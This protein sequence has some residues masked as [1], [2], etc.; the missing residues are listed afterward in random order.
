M[1]FDYIFLDTSPTF[2]TSGQFRLL[3]SPSSWSSPLLTL[4]LE[5]KAPRNLLVT[6]NSLAW[7]YISAESSDR[8]PL[9]TL[10]GQSH[11][12]QSASWPTS[13]EVWGL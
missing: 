4:V 10:L 6:V 2:E 9:A 5:A 12:T 1:A 11:L 13:L 7:I 8:M 3:Y